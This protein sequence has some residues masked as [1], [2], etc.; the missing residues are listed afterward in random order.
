MTVGQFVS[1]VAVAAMFTGL[2][3]VLWDGWRW[4]REHDAE[5]RHNAMRD[6]L[7]GATTKDGHRG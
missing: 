7:R 1:C 6:A 2:G 4:Q 3:R 5:L